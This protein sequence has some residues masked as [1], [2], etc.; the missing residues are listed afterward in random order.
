MLELP[1]VHRPCAGWLLVLPAGYCLRSLLG[2]VVSL[3]IG[4]DPVASLESGL[5]KL[6][7]RLAH[8]V[9][10]VAPEWEEH[11]YSFQGPVVSLQQP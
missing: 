11:S 3:L 2:T 10:H 9:Q 5:S 6:K 7:A 1:H 8:F 4:V